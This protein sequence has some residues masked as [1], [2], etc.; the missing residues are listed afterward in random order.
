MFAAIIYKQADKM[1]KIARVYAE[2]YSGC[3]KV[4]VGAIIERDNKILGIGANKAIPNLCRYR[5]CM[6]VE[7]YGENSK[8]HRNPED[9]RAIHSEI[10]AICSSS[11]SLVGATIYITRYPCEAC[12]RAIVAAGITKVVYGREQVISKETEKILENA[13]IDVTHYIGYKE[14]DT[15]V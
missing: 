5:G 4:K 7:K 6:R 11:E 2:E 3:T 15:I 8:L 13:D 10:D 14:D 12:A 9:C 1:L